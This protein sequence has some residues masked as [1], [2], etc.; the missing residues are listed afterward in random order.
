MSCFGSLTEVSDNNA[1][2]GWRHAMSS[3]STDSKKAYKVKVG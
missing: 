3:A 1:N 2:L